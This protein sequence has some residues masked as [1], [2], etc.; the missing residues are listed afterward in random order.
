MGQ[1]MLFDLHVHTTL[2]SCSN[3]TLPDIL[4]RSRS[5]GYDGICIT[6][7][8]TMDIRTQIREGIQEDGLCIL[9]GMEYDTMDG[10]FL[11]FGPFEGLTHGLTTPDVLALVHGQG[12]VAVAA[13]PFRAEQPLK[14]LEVLRKGMC[15]CV[16]AINGKNSQME[17]MKADAWAKRYSLIPCGGSDAHTI[18]G[19][20]IAGTRFFLPIETRKDLVYALR[21]GLCQPEWNARSPTFS[22]GRTVV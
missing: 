20:G 21:N 19:M 11:L 6:D 16:E 5:L 14:D 2:S 12:G 4:S 13:H 15:R 8:N 9:F 3:L 7:H 1:S 10:H 22:R 18:E 17:N